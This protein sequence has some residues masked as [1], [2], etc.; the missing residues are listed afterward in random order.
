M[1]FYMTGRRH[2]ARNPTS[3]ASKNL[4]RDDK[5]TPS[6]IFSEIP[7]AGA[8]TGTTTASFLLRTLFC[9]LIPSFEYC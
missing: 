5:V 2:F 9:G 8:K 6:A 1:L 7:S 4:G 3:N